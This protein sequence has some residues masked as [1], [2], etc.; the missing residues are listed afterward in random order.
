MKVTFGICATLEGTLDEV[1]NGSAPSVP[2]LSEV[3]E[4]LKT[5]ALI[6]ALNPAFAANELAQAESDRAAAII[7]ALTPA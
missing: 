5:L 1:M 4:T 3:L 7:R 6:V 2:P